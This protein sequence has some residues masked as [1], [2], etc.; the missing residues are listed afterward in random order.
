MGFFLDRYTKYA[1]AFEATGG[2]LTL[3]VGI[4]TYLFKLISLLFMVSLLFVGLYF[5]LRYFLTYVISS[6]VE[7]FGIQRNKFTNKQVN[8]A[9]YGKRFSPILFAPAACFAFLGGVGGD[10]KCKSLTLVPTIAV[11]KFGNTSDDDFSYLLV[12]DLN[13]KCAA[14]VPVVVDQIDTFYNASSVSNKSNMERELLKVCSNSGIVVF[15][16]RSSNSNLF[17]CSIYI[18]ENLRANLNDSISENDRIIRL[19]QVDELNFSIARQSEIVSDFVISLFYYFNSNF[20]ESSLI[21]SRLS[22]IDAIEENL[23]LFRLVNF[24]LANSLIFDGRRDE[25]LELYTSLLNS[26]SSDVYVYNWTALNADQ[27]LDQEV[28]SSIEHSENDGKDWVTSD[29]RNTK[30]Q[31]DSSFESIIPPVPTKMKDSSISSAQPEVFEGKYKEIKCSEG[32]RLHFR[33]GLSSPCSK[34]IIKMSSRKKEFFLIHDGSYYGALDDNGNVIAKFKY[35]DME[36]AKK[37]AIV[38]IYNGP[39]AF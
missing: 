12:R 35:S 19:K 23:S 17:D 13:D 30:P 29:I 7:S 24:F 27:P 5:S 8:L 21:L 16:K 32:K 3:L 28:P 6:K 10:S 38:S 14:K 36:S 26:E 15:G 22:K 18:S 34:E 2:A 39:E 20:S 37:A 25:G 33:S 9:K 1:K 31:R 4:L 11:A